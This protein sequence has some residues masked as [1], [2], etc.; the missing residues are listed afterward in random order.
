MVLTG[1]Q[2]IAFF[3]DADQVGLTNRTRVSSLDAEGISS[4]DD[5]AEWDDDD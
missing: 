2:I 3:E 5:L 1:G 4:I